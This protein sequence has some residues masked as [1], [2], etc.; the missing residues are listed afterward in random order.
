MHLQE[1]LR[2]G[3]ARGRQSRGTRPSVLHPASGDAVRHP[4]GEEG[5]AG[6]GRRSVRRLQRER[7]KP[8]H[9]W[10]EAFAHFVPFEPPCAPSAS[11]T[12]QWRLRGAQA[13]Q[14]RDPHLPPPIP[15]SPPRAHAHRPLGGDGRWHAEPQAQL[16]SRPQDRDCRPCGRASSWGGQQQPWERRTNGELKNSRPT[17]GV[18]EPS[19][20]GL[21][22]GTR[23]SPHPGPVWEPCTGTDPVVSWPPRPTRMP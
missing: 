3:P 13:G 9:V 23:S 7:W 16:P 14:P 4:R 10:C 21:C 8:V 2:G 1:P 6:K 20:Q 15:P 17:A 5:R 22:L 19:S 11:L 18:G 12:L